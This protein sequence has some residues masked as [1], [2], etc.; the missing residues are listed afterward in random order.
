MQLTKILKAPYARMFLAVGSLF[1]V[2]P[3]FAQTLPQPTV[4]IGTPEQGLTAG[5][6]LDIIAAIGTFII[7]AGAALAVIFVVVGG[8]RWIIAGADAEARAAKDTIKNGIIG[9]VIILGVGIL[10][11][12]I[13]TLLRQFTGQSIFF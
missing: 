7:F 4:P 3:T 11:N 5:R 9:G 6:I 2:L 1:S 10:L 12:T 13:A 8:I